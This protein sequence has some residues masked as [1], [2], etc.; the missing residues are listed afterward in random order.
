MSISFFGYKQVNVCMQNNNILVRLTLN[1]GNFF[2]HLGMRVA[3]ILGGPEKYTSPL[4]QV[5]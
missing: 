1:F 3:P 4:F 2:R 5:S